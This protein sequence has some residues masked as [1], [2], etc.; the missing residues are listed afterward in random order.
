MHVPTRGCPI[1]LFLVFRIPPPRYDVH[2]REGQTVTLGLRG[3][4]YREK[5]LPGHSLEPLISIWS[6]CPFKNPPAQGRLNCFC[7]WGKSGQPTPGSGSPSCCESQTSAD[8]T[9]LSGFL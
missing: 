1:T 5:K 3:E 8:Q 2:R 6:D 7:S 4:G 9:F